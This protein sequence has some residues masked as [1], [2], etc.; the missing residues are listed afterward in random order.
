MSNWLAETRMPVPPKTS[1][2]ISDFND[3]RGYVT[4]AYAEITICADD[5]LDLSSTRLGRQ[6]D[7][8]PVAK[9][10]ADHFWR[11]AGILQKSMQNTAPRPN[12]T[13]ELFAVPGHRWSLMNQAPQAVFADTIVIRIARVARNEL[14]ECPNITADEG[15]DAVFDDIAIRSPLDAFAALFSSLALRNTL[16]ATLESGSK[17]YCVRKIEEAPFILRLTR[18]LRGL[19]RQDQLNR[20]E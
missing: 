18:R 2:Q 8:A 4:T 3:Y 14:W 11:N 7:I 16:L 9:G 15:M 6:L 12:D 13:A 20:T 19:D 5:L 17:G 10:L 1:P